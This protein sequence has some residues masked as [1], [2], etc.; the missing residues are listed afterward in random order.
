L[1]LCPICENV[2]NMELIEKLG[3]AGGGGVILL[4]ILYLGKV[5]LEKRIEKKVNHE[6]DVKIEKFRDE[7]R[8]E[9]EVSIAQSSFRYSQIYKSMAEAISEIY[10]RLIDLRE[11]VSHYRLTCGN[12]DSTEFANAS[13]K[14]SSKLGEFHTFFIRNNIY[15][16]EKT[17]D[18][19]WDVYCSINNQYVSTSL[20]IGLPKEKEPEIIKHAAGMNNDIANLLTALR[21]NFHNLLGIPNEDKKASK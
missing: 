12:P 2:G 6:Y 5:L 1:S 13:K 4:A 17:S 14:V 16:P 19:I 20:A 8:R 9:T 18:A 15:I 10:F 11:A 7:L 21:N 3:Y